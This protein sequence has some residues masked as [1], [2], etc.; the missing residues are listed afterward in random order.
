MSPAGVCAAVPRFPAL[1]SPPHDSP[2]PPPPPH[3]CHLPE[4][5]DFGYLHLSGAP[6]HKY[7]LQTQKQGEDDF[8][9]TEKPAVSQLHQQAS[10]SCGAMQQAPQLYQSNRP[11]PQPRREQLKVAS[12]DELL[13]SLTPELQ[14][15]I[16]ER[17]K[18]AA[19]SVH[20]WIKQDTLKELQVRALE[21]EIQ[22]GKISQRKPRSR[23]A[24]SAP[25]NVLE[26][27]LE[28]RAAAMVR[29]VCLS[30]CC[31]RLS[32]IHVQKQI[33]A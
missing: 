25:Q 30:S 20:V 5:D 16:R 28:D 12:I 22:L 26:S 23:Q 13:S 32:L 2:P 17:F 14:A 18:Y 15:S 11:Q 31:A 1:A 21:D 24:E 6:E 33:G 7:P 3:P 4:D 27:G 10:V 8:G 29:V 19:E 9:W